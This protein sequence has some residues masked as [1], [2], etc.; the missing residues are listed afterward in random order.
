MMK[1]GKIENFE[2]REIYIPNNPKQLVVGVV[3]HVALVTT[4]EGRKLK[5]E[6]DLMSSYMVTLK[7]KFL[8]A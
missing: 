3:D 2:G 8:L 1:L 4:E 7:R 5:E 6:I